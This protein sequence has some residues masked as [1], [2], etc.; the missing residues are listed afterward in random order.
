MEINKMK[1]E[2][3]D[4]SLVEVYNSYKSSSFEIN[5]KLRNN[6]PLENLSFQVEC[7]DSLIQGFKTKDIVKL[8]R[9]LPLECIETC[10]I[11]DTYSDKGYCS[12]S[13][14]KDAALQFCKFKRI[15][16]MEIT[17]MPETHMINMELSKTVSG[18]ECEV[19]LGRDS[20]FIISGKEVVKDNNKILDFFDGDKYYAINTK[21]LVIF[22]VSTVN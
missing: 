21:E 19:L 9:V 4:N 11:N 14:D 5:N 3:I 16:I 12:T 20:K 1:Y 8:Y 13:T 22:Y 6:I 10:N 17:C 18:N 7:L 2:D 15:A